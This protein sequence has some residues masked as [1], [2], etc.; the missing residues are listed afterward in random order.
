MGDARQ[1]AG[2]DDLQSFSLEAEIERRCVERIGHRQSYAG[3]WDKGHCILGLKCIGSTPQDI[4]VEQ[5]TLRHIRKILFS[6]C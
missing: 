5:G 2:H 3:P 6:T 4:G 1:Q